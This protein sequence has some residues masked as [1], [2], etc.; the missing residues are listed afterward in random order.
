MPTSVLSLDNDT[1]DLVVF[2][3]LGIVNDDIMKDAY[4]LNPDISNYGDTLP[5]GVSVTVPDLPAATI[6]E[7]TIKLY[8]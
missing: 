1:V 7:G 8:D 4:D 6:V 3:E 5:A 2:R